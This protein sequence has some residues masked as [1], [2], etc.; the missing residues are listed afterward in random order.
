MSLEWVQRAITKSREYM[1][2]GGRG[3][4]SKGMRTENKR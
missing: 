3:E 4:R 2:I 1:R